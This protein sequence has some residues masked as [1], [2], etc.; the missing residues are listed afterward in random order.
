M[1]SDIKMSDMAAETKKS[2]TTGN[3]IT[4]VAGVV[5]IGV[6]V[7]GTIIYFKQIHR[8]SLETEGTRY[9][10]SLR[11]AEISFFK[12]K[13]R[14]RELPI[15][16]VELGLWSEAHESKCGE[17]MDDLDWYFPSRPGCRYQ[18]L[19][20]N[21]RHPK[22]SDFLV[23]ATCDDLKNGERIHV[24]ASRYSEA[25]VARISSLHPPE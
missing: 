19:I 18:V 7:S 16:P 1:C 11:E 13:G 3:V 4:G 2:S 15:C 21:E 14:Y 23:I 10:D 25:D 17:A 24:E 8:V 5:L 9:A 12:K 22:Y 6:F 20:A